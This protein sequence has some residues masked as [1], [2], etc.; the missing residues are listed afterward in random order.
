MFLSFVEMVSKSV[1]G[2]RFSSKRRKERRKSK[3]SNTCF[4]FNYM[5]LIYTKLHRGYAL[6]NCRRIFFHSF[7]NLQI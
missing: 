1:L 5:H 7:L 3:F 6:F 4:E 2:I